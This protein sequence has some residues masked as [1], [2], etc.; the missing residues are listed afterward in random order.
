MKKTFSLILAMQLLCAL[1]LTACGETSQ[2]DV[3]SADLSKKVLEAI[4]RADTMVDTTGVVVEGYMHLSTD[5]FGD[6]S[7]YHNSYGTGVDEFGVFKAGTLKAVEIMGVVEDYLVMLRE[8]SMAALYTPEEVPKLDGAEVR[9]IG[10]YVMY[11]VLSDA[12]RDAAFDAFAS[13]LK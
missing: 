7:V 8:T 12:D 1:F 4:G 5:Q 9:A 11:C 3:S 13:T 10:D 6:C 2:Q